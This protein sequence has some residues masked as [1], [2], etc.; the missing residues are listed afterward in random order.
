MVGAD[1]CCWVRY[2]SVGVEVKDSGGGWR[3]VYRR[4]V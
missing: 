3:E 4:G 1:S 2:V